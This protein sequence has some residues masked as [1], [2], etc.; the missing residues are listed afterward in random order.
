MTL[1]P[2]C[3]EDGICENAGWKMDLASLDSQVPGLKVINFHPMNV[4][5]DGP[6]A[7]C[8]HE[9]LRDNPDLQNCPR[10]IADNYRDPQRPGAET[11]LR[12]LLAHVKEYDVQCL[13]VGQVVSAF[14]AA[15]QKEP[16]RG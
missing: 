11:V 10:E 16:S 15:R 5:I 6:D 1:L 12:Q 9:F 13:R 8:R 4:Y 14:Q 2:Y 7:S 3:W